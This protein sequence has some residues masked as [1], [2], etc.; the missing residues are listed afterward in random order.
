MRIHTSTLRLLV[1][2]GVLTSV[3][4]AGFPAYGDPVVGQPPAPGHPKCTIV[5]DDRPNVI[6]GTNKRDVI[7]PDEGNDVIYG[8]G[9]NDYILGGLGR[10]KLYGGD[11][12]DTFRAWGGKDRVFGENGDD[13][14]NGEIGNDILVGGPGSDKFIGASGNDCM[15]AVDATV[16][17]PAGDKDDL[18]GN[19]GHDRYEADENDLIRGSTES[20]ADCYGPA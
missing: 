6:R 12:N 18:S 4:A 17:N 9:G 14:L 5:G 1:A 13:R 15:F 7:C 19:K 16:E 8:R 20:K 3:L 10:D 11:G 2:L